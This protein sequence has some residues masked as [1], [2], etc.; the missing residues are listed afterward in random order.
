[1]GFIYDAGLLDSWGE[2][3]VGLGYTSNSRDPHQ[4]ID[5]IWHSEDLTTIEVE[6]LQTQASDHLPL[7]S[8]LDLAP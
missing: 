3:G 8:T 6:V 5:W 4:R 1:M 2:A 7:L